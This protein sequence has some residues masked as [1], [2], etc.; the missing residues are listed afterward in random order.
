MP[1]CE[2]A[3]LRT[4][5]CYSPGYTP[6]ALETL[7]LLVFM[8][9]SL[10]A[11]AA[12]A[13][14]RTVNRRTIRFCLV[15]PKTKVVPLNQLSVPGLELQAAVLGTRLMKYIIGGHTVCNRRKVFWSDSNTA[16]AWLRGDQRR[17]HKFVAFRIGE[18][19]EETDISV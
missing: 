15:S 11:Y 2:L 17:F 7:E 8:D 9:A 5:R 10:A 14:F 12:V 18:I 19:Q 3:Q 13:C 16:L 6:V 1:L 4:D